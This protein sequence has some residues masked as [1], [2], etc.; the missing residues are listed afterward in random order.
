MALG[1]ERRRVVWNIL[2]EVVLLAAAGIAISLPVAY[3]ASKLVES[4]LY[5]LKRN[6]PTALTAAALLL[7]AAALL[8]GFVP[9]RRA[10]RIDPATA[11]RNE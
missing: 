3:A 1:A 6:D 9:A 10:A 8:A 5:G 4:F 2:R 7:F 11:L